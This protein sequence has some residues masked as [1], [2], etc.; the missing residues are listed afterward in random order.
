[1]EP[2][3]DNLDASEI[4]KGFTFSIKSNPIKP[5]YNFPSSLI[6]E[7][8]IKDIDHRYC[9]CIHRYKIHK[10]DIL[11]NKKKKKSTLYITRLVSMFFFMTVK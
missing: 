7:N 5:G 4:I 6:F 11:P 8:N 2:G 10:C 1:M 9:R 3:T